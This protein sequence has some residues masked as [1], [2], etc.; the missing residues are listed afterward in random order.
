LGL[1][2]D[3][4]SVEASF[5]FDGS[6]TVYAGPKAKG[7]I[8]I[9]SSVS[10]SPSLKGG[11]YLQF[12]DGKVVDAGL[13]SEAKFTTKAGPVTHGYKSERQLSFVPA[14]DSPMGR[15]FGVGQFGR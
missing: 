6:T 15:A 3:T 8:P 10:T 7:E 9:I 11:G 12:K 13:R 5:G 4:L 2:F 14:P 1:S